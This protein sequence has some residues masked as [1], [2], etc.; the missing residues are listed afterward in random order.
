MAAY[1]DREGIDYVETNGSS[2]E[3]LNVRTCPCCGGSKGKVF[4]N[5]ESGL[6]NCFHGDCE[7]KFNKFKFI[8]A[9]TKLSGAPLYEHIK[10]VAT[11]MG[12][13]P[14]RKRSEPVKLDSDALVLPN[15]FAL[16]L[17]GKNLQYLTN[18][19]ITN[20]ISTYFNLRFCLKGWFK[21]RFDEKD[22]FMNFSNRVI[23]PIFDIDGNLVSFQGRDITNKAEK[24]YLFPPGFAV[25]GSHL[26]NAHNVKETSRIIFG[27]GV[28][29][30][31]AQKIALD[32]DETMRDI[33]PVGT[34]GKHLSLNQFDVVLKLKERGVKEITFM[35]DG[36]KQAIDDAVA[37]AIQVRGLG[38]SARVAVLPKGKDP[39]EVAAS[40]VRQAYR[41]ALPITLENAI[42]IK[43]LS[44]NR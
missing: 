16:P 32:Q 41:D 33:V 3:Q 24:K 22:A 6:G 7:V 20:D 26:F 18:R 17:N 43:M 35:W 23:I 42:K 28:F 40:V 12:W 38:L 5:A 13:R 34:F 27:E 15:S 19:N 44:R 9:H 39:N 31:M 25:T 4:L 1:L 8:K 14:P 36:E 21:Y 10:H 37:A 30:V 2:G 29:D 11:E